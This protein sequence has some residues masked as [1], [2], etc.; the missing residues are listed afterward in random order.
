[1]LLLSD[2]PLFIEFLIEHTIQILR[3]VSNLSWTGKA[4]WWR[5]LG[6]M[7]DKVKF[8]FSVEMNGCSLSNC[9]IQESLCYPGRRLYDP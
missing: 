5:N 9:P 6:K 7:Q 8:G 3:K 2:L 4:Q 1:M